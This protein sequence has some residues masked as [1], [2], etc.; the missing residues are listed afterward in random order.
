MALIAW[1]TR[2]AARS[3]RHVPRLPAAAQSPGNASPWV[4]PVHF[5]VMS[6][7]SLVIALAILPFGS[8]SMLLGSPLMHAIRSAASSAPAFSAAFLQETYCLNAVAAIFSVSFVT[9][10]WHLPISLSVE[11][12]A[13]GSVVP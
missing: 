9:A 10:A 11:I 4:T 2:H 5:F 3:A 6:P 7:L 8:A 13:V 12:T 1:H